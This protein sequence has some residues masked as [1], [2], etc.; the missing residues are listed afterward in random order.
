M[1]QNSSEFRIQNSEFRIQNSEFRIHNSEFR[2]Q[3]Y[4]DRLLALAGF[5]LTTQSSTEHV[6]RSLTRGIVNV[7]SA[8]VVTHDCRIGPRTPQG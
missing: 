4:W 2:I 3:K 7:Y 1:L 5:D 6:D 8:G